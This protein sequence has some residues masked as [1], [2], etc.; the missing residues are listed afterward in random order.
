LDLGIL[1]SNLGSE[2]DCEAHNDL[3][4]D[5]FPRACRLVYGIEQAAANG[6]ERA[7]DK[8][9]DRHDTDLRECE[10]LR[11]SRERKRDDQCQHT[12]T[13]ADWVRVVYALEVYRQIVE[14]DEVGARKEYHKE[15]T[16]PD[17][18]LCELRDLVSVLVIVCVDS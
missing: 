9:E 18:A 5:P 3:E 4:A 1:Q 11:N 16:G 6:T 14:D 10:T 15:S 2:S 12:D 7:A 13:R 17:V 8:P